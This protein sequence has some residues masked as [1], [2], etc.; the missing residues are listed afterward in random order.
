MDNRIRVAVAD[1]HPLYRDGVVSA[2]ES[3]PDI[4]VIAQGETALEALHLARD[5][6][7]DIL[8]LGVNEAWV[9]VNGIAKIAQQW[10]LTKIAVLAATDDEDQVRNALKKGARGYLLKETSSS[11][12][13]SAIRLISK[14][15]SY[16]SPSLAARL[17]TPRRADDGVASEAILGRF[18]ELSHRE[19]QV[20]DLLRQGLSNRLIGDKLGLSEKTIKGYVTVIMEKLQVTNRLEAAMMAAGRT[21]RS[22]PMPPQ[23]PGELS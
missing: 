11:E 14:G 10:P 17:I 15:Q 1:D 6:V 18:P 4:E 23:D 2:L 8:L 21:A 12:L 7:P 3:E 19:E 22:Q 16:V 20:L 9:G 13:I 5:K